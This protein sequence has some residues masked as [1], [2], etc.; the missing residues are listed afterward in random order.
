MRILTILL[1]TLTLALPLATVADPLPSWNDAPAKQAITDF[2]DAVTTEGSEDFVP[3]PERIAVFDNDGTLWVEQPIYTQLAFVLDRLK[4]M[5]SEH[6]EWQEQQPFKAALEGDQ[7]ALGEAGMQGLMKLLM[8]THAGMTSAEFAALAHDWIGTARHS[9]F[10]RPY[11]EL[12]YQPMVELLQYLR[13]NGFKTYI[14]SGGGIAFM[15]PWTE[16]VYGIPPEQVI[17]SQIELAYEVQNGEPV[18]VRQPEIAFIDDKAGKPVGIMRHIGRR[19]ILAFGNSDG[20]YQ[21]LE[22][23]TAGSGS[24]LGL[25]LHHDDAEREYAYDRDSH[26]GGLDQGLDDAADKGW[27]I[28]SMKRDWRAVFPN[29]SPGD[30]Q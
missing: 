20:D 10:E 30:S 24:R 18:I 28:I 6:P 27:Q 2:V 29:D 5:A 11:T 7:Q 26:I 17:G 13:K 19:P 16:Q 3:A 4:A 14:V 21:M 9:R 8:A 1:L 22:W 25:L 12:V 15:R 23:T